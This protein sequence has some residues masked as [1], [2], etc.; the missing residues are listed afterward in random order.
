MHLFSTPNLS[1]NQALHEANRA[2]NVLERQID[3]SELTADERYPKLAQ[4]TLTN[5]ILKYDH[6]LMELQLRAARLEVV[7]HRFSFFEIEQR[8][9]RFLAIETVNAFVEQLSDRVA[10]L[11]QLYH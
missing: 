2:G 3:K 9:N 11:V 5:I 1:H 10:E 4:Q 6:I 7:D 8:L